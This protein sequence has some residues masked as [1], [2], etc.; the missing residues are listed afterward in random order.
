MGQG[1]I[2]NKVLSNLKK[3]ITKKIVDL[4]E[5]K[6]AKIDSENLEKTVISENQLSKYDPLHGVYIYAQNKLSVLVEQFVG[7]PELSKL[8]NPYIKAE[9]MYHPSGPPM[10]PL[11]GSYFF[12]WSV[13][14]LSAGLKKESL[15]TVAIDL[16]KVLSVDP[17]LITVFQSMEKSRMGLYVHEG[18]SGQYVYLREIITQKEIKVI[19]PSGY[20]GESGEIWFV[21]VMPEPFQNLNYGYSVVFTTPYVIYSVKND[22]MTLCSENEW[23]SFFDRNLGKIR[24][25]EKNL[26]YEYFMKYGLD[27]NYWNEFVF[28]GYS[29]FKQDSILL[30]GFPDIPLSR[31]HSKE[32]QEEREYF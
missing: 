9:D 32:S 22:R 13:F 8:T 11:S 20:L 27:R 6:T 12:C 23:I 14:D 17:D 2:S 10:S 24:I 15:G 7:L 1:P 18:T 19:V 31:P 21:R 26:A 28:E 30:T 3:N 29:N 4:S 5:F 25:K 16:C